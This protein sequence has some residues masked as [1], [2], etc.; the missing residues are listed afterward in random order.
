MMCVTA[1]T[2]FLACVCFLIN[3]CDGFGSSKH[4]RFGR[5]VCARGHGH[6]RQHGDFGK[7]KKNKNR[8]EWKI[9]RQTSV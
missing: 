9:A 1:D 7:K 6:V 3:S 4:G 5:R 2:H 8:Y